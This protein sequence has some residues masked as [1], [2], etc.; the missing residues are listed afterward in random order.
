MNEIP[1]PEV[2]REPGVRSPSRWDFLKEQN[3]GSFPLEN[4]IRKADPVGPGN[5]SDEERWAEDLRKFNESNR[6]R[7][8]KKEASSEGQAA[9]EGFV[10]GAAAGFSA[11]A[12][13]EIWRKAK[14]WFWDKVRHRGES[15]QSPKNGDREDAQEVELPP[16][17][18]GEGWSQVDVD[19]R[20]AT[21]AGLSVESDKVNK[22]LKTREEIVRAA[23]KDGYIST[24]YDRASEGIG[25]ILVT[26]TI[27]PEAVR[28][29]WN[30]LNTIVTNFN[31]HAWE[32]ESLGKFN[33]DKLRDLYLK[34][35]GGMADAYQRYLSNE[36]ELE[37]M[38]AEKRL[39]LRTGEEKEMLDLQR[40][41]GM[42]R[43]GP[44]PGGITSMAR[45]YAR[46]ELEEFKATKK[47]NSFGK[48]P[49]LNQTHSSE[50][51]P[52]TPLSSGIETRGGG[53]S[54]EDAVLPEAGIV[55]DDFLVKHGL[56]VSFTVPSEVLYKL[57]RV[58]MKG[59]LADLYDATDRPTTSKSWN[60]VHTQN[61][62]NSC[63]DWVEAVGGGYQQINTESREKATEFLQ[64]IL[65]L[66][67]LIRSNP[68]EYE[69]LAGGDGK[70]GLLEQYGFN[71]RWIAKAFRKDPEAVRALQMFLMMN[72]TT[73][74][75]SVVK[76]EAE[77]RGETPRRQ[78]IDIAGMDQSDKDWAIE[79]GQEQG[80]FME[81]LTKRDH[82]DMTHESA[83]LFMRRLSA[84]VAEK[85][86]CDQLTAE[87]MG[88]LA[89][90]LNDS[91][92]SLDKRKLWFKHS[93]LLIYDSQEEALNPPLAKIFYQRKDKTSPDRN[94][95]REIFLVDRLKTDGIQTLFD[96]MEGP[97]NELAEP[98]EDPFD[99]KRLTQSLKM[100][101]TLVATL[102]E[103]LELR[104][105]RS[106]A[107]GADNPQNVPLLRMKNMERLRSPEVPIVTQKTSE[108]ILAVPQTGRGE[109][110]VKVQ[111]PNQISA[112]MF[113]AIFR[114]FWPF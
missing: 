96:I 65:P 102:E 104:E 75:N 50:N 24:A 20:A 90:I 56:P 17:W 94:K 13:L 69:K 51:T 74:I 108:H 99:A 22:L 18:K 5:G 55:S 114:G 87:L 95:R 12:A 28:D 32:Q 80:G 71:L 81:I 52:L 101:G 21:A 79:K 41:Q 78:Y 89:T 4:K 61:F 64:R 6:N 76:K 86:G 72:R 73:Y 44:V 92:K 54:I 7:S 82:L 25:G 19:L 109:L 110:T 88:E 59:A 97:Q 11:S 14:D 29:G 85:V 31:P 10:G 100:Q 91:P 9:G 98:E 66:L 1:L 47:E 36:I 15:G 40:T 84:D 38:K 62:N 93:K 68:G 57:W 106:K 70:Q 105:G 42:A 63:G 58:D 45:L 112:N 27:D 37:L 53:Y 113:K 46:M 67:V 48:S 3:I 30:K 49:N 43:F 8:K 107:I 26:N 35:Y 60:W 83:R 33:S 111:T 34:K 77:A 39:G 2:G 103:D 16:S 23:E